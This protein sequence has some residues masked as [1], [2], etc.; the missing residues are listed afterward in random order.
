MT[1]QTGCTPQR[2]SCFTKAHSSRL[3]PAKRA[4]MT[5]ASNGPNGTSGLL[6]G[7]K[8]TNGQSAHDNRY[9]SAK[10]STRSCLA[11]Q[12]RLAVPVV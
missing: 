10:Y 12:L 1:Y 5:A 3:P 9:A 7:F 11:A 8:I 6:L 2:P 4:T